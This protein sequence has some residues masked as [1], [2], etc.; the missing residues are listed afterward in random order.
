MINLKIYIFINFEL[1]YIL[2]LIINYPPTLSY[3]MTGLLIKDNS[4]RP[5]LILEI[6]D[7]NLFLV[8]KEG[9]KTATPKFFATRQMQLKSLPIRTTYIH[10]LI[11]RQIEIN[12]LSFIGN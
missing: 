8:S 1:L 7:K 10:A 11:N 5:D 6:S 9:K 12:I 2:Y 3:N 4:S